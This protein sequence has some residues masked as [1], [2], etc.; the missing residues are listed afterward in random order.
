MFTYPRYQYARI[1]GETKSRVITH[2]DHEE[3]E[4]W[5]ESPAHLPALPPAEPELPACCQKLKAKFDAAWEDLQLKLSD[6]D[7]VIARFDAQWQTK[8]AECTALQE[9]LDALK[10]AKGKAPK[11][12]S[13]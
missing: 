7:G 8:V 13:E 6:Q 12:K 5:K 1:D 3:P 4:V 2:P 9:Q 10:S 11:A